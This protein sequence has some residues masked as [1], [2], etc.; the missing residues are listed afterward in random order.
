M[1]GGETRVG[2]TLRCP[3][4]ETR[5]GMVR[6]ARHG[7]GVPGAADFVPK[8]QAG[9]SWRALPR[10]GATCLAVTARRE[11]QAGERSR[12]EKAR[13]LVGRRARAEAGGVPH[14]RHLV[15]CP[16]HGLAR[17][18]ACPTHGGLA[19]GDAA[20]TRYLGTLAWGA[21]RDSLSMRH[22]GRQGPRAGRAGRPVACG[23]SKRA[24][25]MAARRWGVG[26][27][28]LQRGLSTSGFHSHAAHWFSTCQEAR[29]AKSGPVAL[30]R[31]LREY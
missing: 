16:T 10:A 7:P 4:G 29:A 19:R 6:W 26:G 22:H 8:S 21:D 1:A 30:D 5:V 18:V 13:R 28:D 24:P 11:A 9:G 14:A 12:R 17:L 25:N 2:E 3:G 15:A 27:Q 20:G 23:L 31:R